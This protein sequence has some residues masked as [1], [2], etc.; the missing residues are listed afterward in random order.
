M[1]LV[2]ANRRVIIDV[3]LQVIRLHANIGQDLFRAIQK[4]SSISLPAI[5]VSD[6]ERHNRAGPA[7]AMHFDEDKCNDLAK[8]KEAEVMNE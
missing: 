4:P 6:V 7:G 1:F 8:A 5:A 3:N 2:K